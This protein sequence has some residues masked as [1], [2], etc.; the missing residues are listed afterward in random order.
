MQ[1]S[2]Q[3]TP[4]DVANGHV[5]TAEGQWVPVGSAPA[6]EKPKKPIYKRWWFI[7]IA[8]VFVFSA[9]QSA[10]GGGDSGTT[11]DEATTSTT[12][13]DSGATDNSDTAAEDTTDEEVA[14]EEPA[15][16]A[17]ADKPVKVAAAKL[18]KEF[19]NNELAADAKYKGKTLLVTGEVIQIDTEL[20]DDD[21]YYVSLG[22]G[23]DFEFLFVN[24]HDMSTDELAT[25]KVGDKVTLLGT[26]DDGGDLGVE[27]KDSKLS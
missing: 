21:K 22:S 4:G 27:V 13:E 20:L 6:P 24:F 8:I 3:H 23:S 19:E 7:A 5:L 17:P 25:L 10:T 1:D 2:V 16:A 9:I 18:V 11:T 26:F 14:D 12:T 15:Q